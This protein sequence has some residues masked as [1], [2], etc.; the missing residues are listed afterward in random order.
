[1]PNGTH[2][3][4]ETPEVGYYGQGILDANN[5]QIL[6]NELLQAQKKHLKN[7]EKIYS[8]HLREMRNEELRI[9]YAKEVG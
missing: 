6:A 1:M 7:I 9:R 4:G 5:S 3:Q 8:D 2:P